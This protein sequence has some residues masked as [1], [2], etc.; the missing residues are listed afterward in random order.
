MIQRDGDDEKV[1]ASVRL[2]DLLDQAVAN[3][4]SSDDAQKTRCKE[5]ITMI[6]SNV[7]LKGK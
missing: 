3:K 6:K 7:K 2:K 1:D 4:G 5:A